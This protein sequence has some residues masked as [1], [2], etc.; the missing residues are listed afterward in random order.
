M[1]K[2]SASRRAFLQHSS[3]MAALGAGAPFA[4]NLSAMGAAAAQTLPTD[5][6]ALVCVYMAGG[7]DNYN[8][9]V[10]YDAPSQATYN[11]LRGPLAID[12]STLLPL[13]PAVALP[14][15]RA[16]AFAPSLSAFKPLFDDAKLAVLLNVGS[17]VEPVTKAQYVARS[18]DLPPKLQSHNDQTS[19]WQSSLPE[20]A[21]SGWAGRLADLV[22]DA[23]RNYTFSSVAVSSNAVLMSGNRVS[24]YQVSS[25]GSVLLQAHKNPTFG[26]STVSS[27]LQALVTEQ[28]SHLMEN[29]HAR[30]MRRSIE[31][32][33]LLSSALAAAP[34]LSTAFPA[35]SLGAQL[36]MVARMISVRA[37]LGA[38]RQ[39]FYVQLGGFDNHSFLIQN[40]APLIEQVSDAMA[41]FYRA[42][43]EMA[44]AD[45]VTSFTASEFGRSL[46]NNGDGSDH[47]WGSFHF[48]LGGAVRGRRFYGT[49]PE[50][51][52][53]GADDIGQGRLIPTTSVDQ[54]AATLGRW[55][56]VS[57]TLLTTALPGLPNFDV[58]ARNLGFLG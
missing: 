38:K 54:Y 48:V 42:T 35:T 28:R 30:V 18:R 29:E 27:A 15:A 58:G 46:T 25:T 52:N 10:P 55:F 44:V 22:A 33:D 6:R 31:A 8:T 43:T 5:Y 11:A 53:N 21:K 17:L 50:I 19:F 41:A 23:N 4:L 45:Q 32:D 56:G 12:A 14:N 9:V 20:G 51:A 26:S 37:A 24:Q 57:D 16:F 3:A 1:K 36:K 47:G 7:N 13:Q 34:A 49:A 40:H 39:V 2:L